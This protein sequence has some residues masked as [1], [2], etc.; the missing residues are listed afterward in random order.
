MPLVSYMS[1]AFGLNWFHN[2]N[3]PTS[4]GFCSRF[5]NTSCYLLSPS[6]FPSN[7]SRV[8]SWMNDS[9]NWT[10]LLGLG[11]PSCLVWCSFA[12]WYHGLHCCYLCYSRL[13]FALGTDTSL[14]ID[15]KALAIIRVKQKYT[16]LLLVHILLLLCNLN[17][18]ILSLY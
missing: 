3:V 15:L 5:S 7:V 9:A 17:W 6:L 11:N 16:L 2:R 1:C 4:G 13:L 10:V 18:T 12:G 14:A 8:S